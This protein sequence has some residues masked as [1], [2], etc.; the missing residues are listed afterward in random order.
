MTTLR[1]NVRAFWNRLTGTLLRA[2]GA[3]VLDAE[4]EAHIAMDTEAGVKAG[5]DAVEAR[6]QALV[7][8]GGAE[9][10]RQAYRE[11]AGLTWVEDLLRDL[12]YGTRTWTRQKPATVI[13]VLTLAIGIGA[14]TAIF[15]AIKPILISPL[16]YPH[17]S[18]LTMVWETG[19]SGATSP[20]TFGTFYGVHQESHSFEELAVYK[21][22]QPAASP[23]SA[24]ERPE[25]LDGQRVS[26]D[27]FRTL[28]VSPLRGRDFQAADDRFRGP[29]VVILSDRIWRTRFA[30]DAAIIGKQ[31]RLDDAPYTVIGVMPSEFEN[32]LSSSAEIWA[33]LQYD[34]SLPWDGREWGHHLHMI[35]RL[36]AEISSE[37]AANELSIVLRSLAQTYAKGYNSSGGAPSGM[38]VHS[39]KGDLTEAVRPALLAI[40]GAVLLVLLIACVNVANLQLARGVQRRAEFAMRAALGATRSRLVRQ[41]LAESLL[42]A[43]IGCA[44]GMAIAE[45]GVRMLL[46]LSPP[47]LPRLNVIALDGWVFVF[48]LALTTLIGIAVGLISAFQASGMDLHTGMRQSS[49]RSIDG[50]HRTRRILVVTEVSLAVVLLVSAGLLLRSMERL[51]AVDPGF[52]ASNLITM[53]VQESG[54]RYDRD[55][56]R[57]QFFQEALDR[58]RQLPGVASAGLTSQLP[59]SGDQDI[60]GIEFEKDH[61]PLGEPA[62]RYAV[63]PGYLEAMHIPL[64]RGRMLNEQDRAGAPVAVLITESL[65]REEF[66]GQD[67]IGQR[68]HMGPDAGQVGKPWATI[69][70]VVGNVKQESLALKQEEAFYIT[71]AQWAWGDAVQSLVVRTHVGIDPATLAPAVQEAV[72]SVDKTRPITRVATMDALVAATALERRF[73]LVLFEAFGVVA[74]VL[75]AIGIY[76]ILAGSVSERTREMG[77]RAALGATRADIVSLVLRQGMT[78]TVIGLAIGMCGALAAGRALDAMLFGVTWLDVVTYVGAIALLFAVSCIACLIPARRAASIDPMEALRNE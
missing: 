51:L 56:A 70:G 11:R 29:N 58:V 8:L 62:F 52:E 46:D 72:W 78:M 10:T 60:Y 37:Q 38:A 22:W 53:Q 77:V 40:V 50:H 9:Q 49:G 67:P 25:R 26:A 17:A 73:V 36:K 28:G 19:K 57:L 24:A 41:L 34:S 76:G 64:R 30:S 45:A 42:I 16:P 44:L 1:A 4:L 68:V 65:A 3:R 35:G 75:A 20:V 63:S 43:T 14:S 55:A 39:L 48:A 71:N 12:V 32:V 54:H 74:L 47:G 69:V 15:S 59:L 27:Y 66:A 5:L 6:R 13:A 33:P 21:G 61:N 31:I 7:R 2:D 18:R 23:T